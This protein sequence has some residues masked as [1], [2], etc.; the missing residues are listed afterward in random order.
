MKIKLREA[1][2]NCNFWQCLYKKQ[3]LLCFLFG[4][5]FITV[6]ELYGRHKTYPLINI[7]KTFSQF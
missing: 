6:L 4:L 1:L 2:V 5:K 7:G 3:E